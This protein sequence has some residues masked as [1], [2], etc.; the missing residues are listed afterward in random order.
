MGPKKW[1]KQAA[2]ILFRPQKR[3]QICEELTGQRNFGFRCLI[4]E[5][6]EFELKSVNF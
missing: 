2:F 3:Q 4:S 1:P 6:S 5:E